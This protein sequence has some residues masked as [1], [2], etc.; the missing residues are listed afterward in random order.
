MDEKTKEMMKDPQV[1]EEIRLAAEEA[2]KRAEQMEKR[3]RM[4][5]EDMMRRISI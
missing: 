3:L 2:S 5:P 4:K 1:V